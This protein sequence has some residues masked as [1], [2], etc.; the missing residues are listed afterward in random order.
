MTDQAKPDPKPVAPPAPGEQ[1]EVPAEEDGLPSL[2]GMIF[3]PYL[4]P[5]DL[6]GTNWNM[7][8]DFPEMPAIDWDA[9]P[10]PDEFKTV[11]DPIFLAAEPG[12]ATALVEK[13]EQPNEPQPRGR[14]LMNWLQPAEKIAEKITPLGRPPVQSPH[15]SLY[16]NLADSSWI[17]MDRL[18]ILEAGEEVLSNQIAPRLNDA[19]ARTGAGEALQPPSLAPPIPERPALRILDPGHTLPLST[20]RKSAAQLMLPAP[21]SAQELP[22]PGKELSALP[23][24]PA[25][26]PEEIAPLLFRSFFKPERIA[27]GQVRIPHLGHV[28]ILALLASI[29]LVGAGLLTRSALSFHLFGV[30]TLQGAMSDVHYTIGSMAA[31]YLIAF[32][33][34]LLIFP[35]F[36]HKNYFAG[37]QWN[38]SSALH[39]VKSLL[40]AASVCFVLALVD[41]VVLPGPSNAP[42]DKLFDTRTA[43]WLLFAFGV[44][45]APFFEETV[46]RGFLLPA[47]C[48]A[49][50]WSVER[51]TGN[52]ARP[53]D[54]LGHPRW[55]LGAMVFAS[56]ATSV[57]FALMHAEQ[58]AWSLGP[59]LLLVA[60]SL[61]LSWARLSTRSLAAS[62]L[63]HASYNFLLFS[64]MLLGTGGFR[65]LDKM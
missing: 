62:V 37:L 48:T 3:S 45:F 26:V 14:S 54:P 7:R 27:S 10:S 20:D 63:V 44:T 39:H 22:V 9:L 41:E 57:P 2:Q 30:S 58:T 24:V 17:A 28:A 60:V 25:T 18:T 19:P 40:A 43:A 51:V 49:F 6:D 47:L 42:I 50:D 34:A 16:G 59:L 33:A 53:L 21:S 36:W 8:K 32:G 61:V 65:H 52:P 35:L 64:L 23:A 55:S 4:D 1:A 56:I 31:L 11:I 12:P 46:F 15:P 29:G 5:A 13:A 38:A